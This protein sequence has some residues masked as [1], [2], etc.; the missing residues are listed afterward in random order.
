MDIR[1]I[2]CPPGENVLETI[3]NDVFAH[4]KDTEYAARF[5]GA[6]LE[7]K[8]HYV[9]QCETFS[10]I[11]KERDDIRRHIGEALRR[12]HGGEP[13][14]DTPYSLLKVPNDE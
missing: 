11:L 3:I 12:A 6:N 10:D 13:Q 7:A 4:R 2:R 9:V 8:N 5:F 1:T 14:T